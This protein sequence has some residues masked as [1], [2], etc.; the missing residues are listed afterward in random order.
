MDMDESLKDIHV[1][2]W[3]LPDIH[4]AQIEQ[5]TFATAVSIPGPR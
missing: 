5:D 4:Y 3:G 2:E 1:Q